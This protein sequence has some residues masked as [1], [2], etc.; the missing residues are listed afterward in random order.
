[1][2][3]N[4]T[5]LIDSQYRNRIKYENP[6]SFSIQSR[7][8]T[9][10][11]KKTAGDPL[12]IQSP[13][14]NWSPDDLILS[15]NVE[16][17]FSSVTILVKTTDYV[18]GNINFYSGINIRYESGTSA[19]VYINNMIKESRLRHVN[20]SG[21]YFI[22]LK[23]KDDNRDF[24][25]RIETG[26]TVNF[27]SLTSISNNYM[28]VPGKG[29]LCNMSSGEY[30]ITNNTL[31]PVDNYA[32]INFYND[33]N[34]IAY[35]SGDLTGWLSSHYY[36]LRMSRPVS[37]GL[38]DSSITD[39]SFTNSKSEFNITSSDVDKSRQYDYGRFLTCSVSSV[40]NENKYTNIDQIYLLIEI[41]SGSVSLGD[42]I[43]D[44]DGNSVKILSEA[45]KLNPLII[46]YMYK[47]SLES[48]TM[49]KGV[50]LDMI[51]L[52]TQN[53]VNIKAYHILI[54]TSEELPQ[55]PQPGDT[56]E[57]LE[58]FKDNEGF[59]QKDNILK[60]YNKDEKTL[61]KN[62]KI[63][64]LELLIPNISS[65]YSSSIFEHR[66]LYIKLYNKH[67][68][69]TRQ[70]ITNSSIKDN[71]NMSFEVPLSDKYCSIS[72]RFIIFDKLP[73]IDVDS[74]IDLSSDIH[75]EVCLPDGTVY[76]PE[77][78]DNLPPLY[79]KCKLQVTAKFLIMY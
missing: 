79:P 29:I 71:M 37:Y 70:I 42:I 60:I 35:L 61:K 18:W 69:Q 10:F 27:V 59:I 55:I 24:A 12:S 51:N 58:I 54:K 34:N 57:V 1:M 68:Q 77:E 49:T 32:I 25:K 23:L 9:F 48:G 28:F 76:Q 17:V 7:N 31:G 65:N 46:G 66:Y 75:F 4:E 63:R 6:Y 13:I 78:E 47:V 39:V 72:D 8:R 5:L 56:F 15:G 50:S 3:K 67:F 62:K 45:K 21:E 11:D 52:S 19:G 43:K 64:L 16:S 20:N 2:S 14:I 41:I 38:V 53:T 73:T 22:E 30:I 26:F 74:I 40:N 44:S 36:S 33:I